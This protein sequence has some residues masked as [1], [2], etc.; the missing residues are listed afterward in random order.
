[1]PQCTHSLLLDFPTLTILLV[2]LLLLLLILFVRYRN[3]R[4]S[5]IAA[6]KNVIN[7][8]R[9]SAAY[10]AALKGQVLAFST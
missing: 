5:Y 7:W 3:V 1:M 2:L 4:A 6:F 10:D 8:A 9:V